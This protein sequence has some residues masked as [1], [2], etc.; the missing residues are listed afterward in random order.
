MSGFN[1]MELGEKQPRPS[2]TPIWAHLNNRSH[3]ELDYTHQQIQRELAEQAITGI[4]DESLG[5][6]GFSNRQWQLD[7]VPYILPSEDFAYLSSQLSARAQAIEGIL[8]DL[9]G[10]R[11]LLSQD[12]FPRRLIA[13]NPSFIRALADERQAGP[14]LGC[15]AADLVRKPDGQWHLLAD[16]CQAPL[17][18]AMRCRI[19]W[20][21]RGLC[22][23]SLKK[24]A[25]PA[26]LVFLSTLAIVCGYARAANNRASFYS[27]SESLGDTNYEQAFLARYLDID[28]VSAADLTVHNRQVFTKTFRACS[29]WMLFSAGS[30]TCGVTRC[31]YARI[32]WLGCPGW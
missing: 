19:V 27:S 13:E 12:W 7:S 32:V 5:N 8:Q 31:F 29:K 24:V 20:S 16:R 22:P 4:S 1:E 11:S 9:Y 28:L 6:D 25:S 23:I 3:A 15:Y 17:A 21:W 14:Y 30:M 26:W 18:W 10:K 2:W